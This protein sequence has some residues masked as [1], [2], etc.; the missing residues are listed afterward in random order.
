MSVTSL[1]A[2]FVSAEAIPNTS[3]LYG[4]YGPKMGVMPQK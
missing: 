2:F 1:I 3:K 4:E